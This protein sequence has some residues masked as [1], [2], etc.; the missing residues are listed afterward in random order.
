[1][2]TP[3]EDIAPLLRI[4]LESAHP[5]DLEAPDPEDASTVACE[6]PSGQRASSS[7]GDEHSGTVFGSYTLIEKLGEGGF[8]TVWLASQS[9]PVKRNVALKI[10]SPGRVNSEVIARFELER[11]A[12]AV[13]DHPNIARVFDAG[14][15][16]TGRPYFVMEV[17]HGVPVTRYCDERQLP[18]RDRLELFIPVCQAVQHAHAKGIIHRDLKPSNVLVTEHDGSPVPKVIDFGIAKAIEALP[19]FEAAFTLEGQV[20][21]TPVY[22]S[23]EQIS[24]RTDVD[25]RSDIYSLGT[26][27]YELLVGVTPVD[28]KSLREAGWAEV[29]RVICQLDPPR[30]SLRAREIAPQTVT[31]RGTDSTRITK[32]LRGDLDWIVMKALE[33]DRERRYDTANALAV[34]IRS[35][36]KNQPVSASPPSVIYQFRKFAR[37]NRGK[38][39]A[40]AAVMIALVAGLGMSL[41]QGNIARDARAVA[42]ARL[43]EASRSLHA[44][45]IRLRDTGDINLAIAKAGRAVEVQPENHNA[46]SFLAGILPRGTGQFNTHILEG[47][48]TKVFGLMFSPDGN[49]LASWGWEIDHVWDE[50]PARIWDL[51]DETGHC[52]LDKSGLSFRETVDVE[53]NRSGT[54]AI[55]EPRGT[56]A[57]GDGYWDATSGRLIGRGSF[58]LADQFHR[59]PTPL[60][61][62]LFVDED[63]PMVGIDSLTEDAS[64][65]TN[66]R[67]GYLHF[68]N[69]NADGTLIAT[70]RSDGWVIES[71]TERKVLRTIPLE[72]DKGALYAG[73]SPDSD[74]LLLVTTRRVRIWDANSGELLKESPLD[75]SE[76]HGEARNAD[77]S[78]ALVKIRRDWQRPDIFQMFRVT[79]QENPVLSGWD[80]DSGKL[81]GEIALPANAQCL[82]PPAGDCVLWTDRKSHLEI[83]NLTTWQTRLA[84][85]NFGAEVLNEFTAKVSPDGR[86]AYLVMKTEAGNPYG[87]HKLIDIDSGK[88][89]REDL[90]VAA[91]SPDGTRIAGRVNGEN[92]ELVSTET[93]KTISRFTGHSAKITNL[94]FSGDGQLVASSSEDRTV[95]V[96][97]VATPPDDPLSLNDEPARQ[98]IEW[99]RDSVYR[100]GDHFA[101]SLRGKTQLQTNYFGEST[102]IREEPEGRRTVQVSQLG[103][104]DWQRNRVYY[105]RIAPPED[106]FLTAVGDEFGV[107]S[108]KVWDS[109]T[110]SELYRITNKDWSRAG[111]Y[112]KVV[113]FSES[114]R[115]IG[116]RIDERGNSGYSWVLPVVAKGTLVPSWVYR[117]LVPLASGYR[118]DETGQMVPLSR[119]DLKAAREGL[120]TVLAEF[121]ASD[122]ELDPFQLCAEWLTSNPSFRRVTPYGSSTVNE[123]VEKVW[124]ST[125]SK[126]ALAALYRAPSNPLAYIALA[127]AVSDPYQ[128][129]VLRLHAVILFESERVLTDFGALGLYRL[130]SIASPH[131]HKQGHEALVDRIQRISQRLNLSEQM[132]KDALDPPSPIPS[133]F[134]WVDTDFENP[135]LHLAERQSDG[136]WTVTHPSGEK[137]A[138]S[139]GTPAGIGAYRS[140]IIRSKPASWRELFIPLEKS[141]EVKSRNGDKW[142]TEGWMVNRVVE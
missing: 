26:L 131:L 135:G 50:P 73:F 34:D 118:A 72:L 38:L 53:F 35:Y 5:S 133:R 51:Q 102:L 142:E 31:C 7:E 63:G 116:F 129:Y 64:L 91:F 47:H 61:E 56:G 22:M 134:E 11:Q 10:L 100:N 2:S 94:L 141:D 119:A 81:L 4:G 98:K 77:S 21:G 58:N 122:H 89:L 65:V 113:E 121:K 69:V 14:T 28:V 3:E 101:E 23:P 138:Y 99:S 84:I 93:G 29:E 126:L 24:G 120:A 86:R 27:L 115:V 139:P 140:M 80:L 13:M 57:A 82:L 59:F 54:R 33:K 37:R 88:V 137:E 123:L 44:E 109:E 110:G 41:W 74:E 1:M 20:I 97:R 48:E 79:G 66:V 107:L 40:G 6:P 124:E 96:Y 19:N 117:F 70:L 128:A 83:W 108:C 132:R 17:V 8:G 62:L 92:W 32:R 60:G 87:P 127:D 114:G 39:I 95:R 15:T 25:T 36:L 30:P 45:A 111:R 46:A 12:L 75:W 55:S 104:G 68:V 78:V 136:G 71:T 52:V 16:V 49:R 67:R 9:A 103:E 90:G 130:A 106:L 76:K 125:D 18:L 85:D 43:W 42:E 105:G 112:S